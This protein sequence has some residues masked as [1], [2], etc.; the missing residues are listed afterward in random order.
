[1]ALQVSLMGVMGLRGSQDG[2]C[3]PASSP[4]VNFGVDEPPNGGGTEREPESAANV[5]PSPGTSALPL[6]GFR[7]S[8]LG[9]TCSTTFLNTGQVP[10]PVAMSDDKTTWASAIPRCRRDL[11]NRD[12]FGA[13][14]NR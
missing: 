11:P 3:N 1:M 13:P 10:K 2:V 4:G 6:S 14:P 8:R 5:K 7:R 12:T 9:G